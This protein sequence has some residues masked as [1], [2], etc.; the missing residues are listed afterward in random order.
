MFKKAGGDN[1]L[2]ALQSLPNNLSAIFNE[3]A[4]LGSEGGW[5]MTVNIEFARHLAVHEDGRDDL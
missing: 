5:E 3:F 1:A 4:I 2:L